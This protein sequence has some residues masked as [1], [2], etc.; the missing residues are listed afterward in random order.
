MQLI[1]GIDPGSLVTGYAVIRKEG[2]T[3][4][5][6]SSGEIRLG[7]GVALS[8][9][10]AQL[11]VELE[12]VITAAN[13]DVA[14]VED[15]FFAKNA[16]SALSLGQARGAVLAAL[17]RAN[18]AV[19]SYP[20]ALVKQAV[21]GHGRAEKLQIQ[22]MVKAL[23]SIDRSPGADE[24]DAMAIAICHAMSQPGSQGGNQ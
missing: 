20:P 12:R 5:L 21:A 14:A 11:Q 10:L 19:S 23:L 1:L 9:R 7:K 24:A 16:R 22:L 2:R 15:V 8:Q 17:G 4:Q 13:P 3:L 6:V 18:L